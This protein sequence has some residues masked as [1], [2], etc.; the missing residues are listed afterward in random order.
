MKKKI[1]IVFILL[2]FAIQFIRPAKNK[3]TERSAQDISSVH[4]IPQPVSDILEKSC[5]DCHS[6]NTIYPWYAEIQPV[7]WWLNDHIEEG[8]EELNFNEFAS[9]KIARQFKKLEEITEQIKK[10]E[11][12]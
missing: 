2:L 9:Y 3:M 5:N 7:G 6:N 12:Q 11:M 1:L 8:K 4:N 10:D